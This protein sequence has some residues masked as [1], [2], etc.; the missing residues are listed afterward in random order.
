MV[1]ASRGCDVFAD[2]EPDT[3]VNLHRLVESLGGG[4]DVRGGDGLETGAVRL[5]DGGDGA[6]S[7][8][9]TLAA[10]SMA[11]DSSSDESSWVAMVLAVVMV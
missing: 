1:V 4:E 5:F 2:G 3:P 6:L 11:H 8:A 10:V 9:V 7:A